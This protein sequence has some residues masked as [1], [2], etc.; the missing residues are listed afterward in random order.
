[1]KAHGGSDIENDVMMQ[2]PEPELLSA[3]GGA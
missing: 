1:M 3:M 2:A